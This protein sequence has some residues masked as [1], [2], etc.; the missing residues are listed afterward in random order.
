[1]DLTHNSSYEL[2]QRAI[3]AWTM[4]ANDLVVVQLGSRDGHS[5]YDPIAP[6]LR[7]RRHSK[8]L[9]VE[10]LPHAFERLKDS[11]RDVGSITFDNLAIG[12]RDG[13]QDLLTTSVPVLSLGSLCDKA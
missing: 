3:L 2:I 7:Q 13:I 6:L 12:E 1:V 8:A 11:Y 9:L 10:P 5:R 4:P